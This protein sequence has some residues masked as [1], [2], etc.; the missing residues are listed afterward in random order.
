ME[1]FSGFLHGLWIAVQPLNLGVMIIGVRPMSLARPAGQTVR[2]R[3]LERK[4][5][6]VAPG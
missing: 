6:D 1:M 2:D 5:A 3:P 4:D